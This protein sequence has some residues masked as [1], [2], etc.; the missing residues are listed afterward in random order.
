MAPRVRP[1]AV[2]G[3][4]VLATL[5]AAAPRPRAIEKDLPVKGVDEAIIFARMSQRAERQAFHDRYVRWVGETVRRISIIS[6]YRRVVLLTEE[7]IRLGDAS[8]SVRQ[9]TTDLQPW[10][11]QVEVIV[12]L[13]F[14]PQNTFIGVPLID[15]LLVPLDAPGTLPS[16]A[17]ATDRIPRFGVY[18]EPTPP[19]APWWPYPPESKMVTP[20]AEPVTGGWVRT[21]FDAAPL[22]GGRFEVVIKEGVKTLDSAVFDF[23]ALR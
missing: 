22:A 19:D 2:V 11:G 6:E 5:V 23:G 9:M 13:T 12:E 17:D 1:G 7:R 20:K 10:R 18:W 21:R 15:V 4:I 3:L 14:H 16:T 8:Y